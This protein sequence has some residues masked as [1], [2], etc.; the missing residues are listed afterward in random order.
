MRLGTPRFQQPGA[1][2]GPIAVCSDVLGNVY[3]T[4]T[5]GEVWKIPAGFEPQDDLGAPVPQDRKV[6]PDNISDFG[7]WRKQ[8]NTD[9]TFEGPIGISVD[10]LGRIIVQWKATTN[11]GEVN[12]TTRIT[13]D[14]QNVEE[15]SG[16]RT[17]RPENLGDFTGYWTATGLYP[18]DD[19]NGDGITNID[20]LT[21]PSPRN[22][23]V[24]VAVADCQRIP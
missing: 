14:G 5:R 22:P 4:C 17:G 11:D 23:F 12:R 6:I 24:P 1:R 7:G 16:V 19:S 18:C 20:S 9:F 21:S 2:K 10:G 3:V 8:F 13:S 15:F